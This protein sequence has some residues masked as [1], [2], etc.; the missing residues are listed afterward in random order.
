MGKNVKCLIETNP[1]SVM[2]ENLPV[3]KAEKLNDS[4]RIDAII[5]IPYYDKD[6]IKNIVLNTGYKGKLYSIDDMLEE[7]L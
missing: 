2:Y 3:L 7:A 4:E 1:S 6:K 5:I